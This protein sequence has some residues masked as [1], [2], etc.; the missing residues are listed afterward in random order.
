MWLQMTAMWAAMMVPMMLPSLIPWLRRWRP[1]RLAVIA[2]CGYFLV[3][4][5]LGALVYPPT[6]LWS[7][8]RHAGV[9][10]LAAGLLQL[11]P[12]KM[13][14]L[15][16]C[17]ASPCPSNARNAWRDGLMMG[18]DCSL[19]CA[20]YTIVLLVIGAMNLYVMM[21]VAVAITIERLAPRPALVART[22]GVVVIAAGVFMIASAAIAETRL[23]LF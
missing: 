10:L 5:A 17:R 19:C 21:T 12:W 16:C 9:A 4:T 8:S 2:V 22:V 1:R 11:T 23:T 18:V 15:D 20:S 6:M 14:K 13:R 3:W 7:F